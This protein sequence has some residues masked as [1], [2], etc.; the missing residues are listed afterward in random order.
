[1]TSK[2]QRGHFFEDFHK[3]QVLRHPTPRTV[4]DGDVALYIGL[5]GDRRPLHCST[6]FAQA[7]GYPGSPVHDWLAFHIV[8]GKSVGQIS[9]N[10]VANLGYA[11]GRFLRP[12]YPGDT[13][14]AESEVLGTKEVS[15]GKAGIVWVRTRGLNQRDEEVLRY[16]RWVMVEKRDPTTKTGADDAPELPA[17]VPA[18]ELSVHRELDLERFP[19]LL[20]A[21][22]GGAFFEDYEVGE[23]ID[24]VDGMT[25]DEVDHTTATRLYQNTA[26]VHFNLH[27]MAGS[28]FG[29]RLMY[30]GHVISVASALAYG[31]FENALAVLALNGGSHTHPTFAGDTL[32]AWS[33]VLEKAALP[34]RA[35]AGALRVR[36]CAAKN[37]DPS[38][39][40]F[41]R[42]V[43]DESGKESPD[44][45]LVL[46]LDLW[47]LVPRR[48]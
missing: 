9:L 43:R 24:H 15:S 4:T 20:W 48:R 26:R 21:T 28:R 42:R 29:R 7:L 39:E 12:V 3:G 23:R 8:F 22:G 14:R 47:L 33:E 35:D 45:R 41:E 40:P 34:G 38:K 2:I 6:T 5:T 27:Q 18:S 10:A 17:C 19:D 44:P 31:G 36:L 13:L 32:Y 25:I 46:E 11:D 30:G 1:M 37:H 16:C